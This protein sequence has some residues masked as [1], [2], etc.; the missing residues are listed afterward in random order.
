M[1]GSINKVIL[2]GNLGQDPRVS[3]TQSGAKVVSFS[4]ATTDTWRDKAS[5]ERRDRTE[6]HRIVIFS[7][8]LADTAE[9]YLRK[10]SKVYLEGSLQTREWDDQNGQKRYTTEVVLQNF[11]S[12]LVMLDG[13]G[14]SAPAGAGD[15]Y[16]SSSAGAGWDNTP[17]A[18]GDAGVVDDDI[19]F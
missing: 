13:R 3:N 12:T 2:V 10:G 4:L 14:D 7:P 9:R 16:D 15:I 18:S 19:P 1:A 8:G 17:A 11:N 6:W 5:G